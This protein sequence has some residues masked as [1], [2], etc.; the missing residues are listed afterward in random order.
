L[1]YAPLLGVWKNQEGRFQEDVNK[2]STAKLISVLSTA[3]DRWLFPE[4]ICTAFA[5]FQTHF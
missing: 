1:S 2:F 3:L 4:N 5:P